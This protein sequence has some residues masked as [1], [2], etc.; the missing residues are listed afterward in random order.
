MA[1]RRYLP[2]LR[3]CTMCHHAG[4]LTPVT[5][6]VAGE[7]LGRH[8]LCVKCLETLRVFWWAVRKR[9][10]RDTRHCFHVQRNR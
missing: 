7:G 5:L 8:E 3:W 10:H 4:N 1:A 2:V 6:D 9:W